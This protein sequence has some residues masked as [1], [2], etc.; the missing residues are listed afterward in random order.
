MVKRVGVGTRHG[1]ESRCGNQ[2][3]P[4]MVKR[5]GVGTRKSKTH[6]VQCADLYRVVGAIITYGGA[7]LYTWWW[8][9]GHKQLTRS[10]HKTEDVIEIV[11]N[12]LIS[13]KLRI[14]K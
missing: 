9:W 1:K 12:I 4:Y 5:V 6:V 7:V 2:T 3:E 13:T 8:V 11:K 14:E 10:Y